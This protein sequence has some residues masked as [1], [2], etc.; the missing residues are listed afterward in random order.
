[1]SAP[2]ATAQQNLPDAHSCRTCL[3]PLVGLARHLAAEEHAEAVAGLPAHA[4]AL[5]VRLRL[6]GI[7]GL[8]VVNGHWED[9][10]LQNREPKEAA[11]YFC[12]RIMGAKM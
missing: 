1:M 6:D 7:L 8:G 12:R 3:D 2:T 4:H 10:V 9:K 11:F 5:R